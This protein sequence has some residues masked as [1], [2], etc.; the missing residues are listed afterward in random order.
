MNRSILFLDLA[1]TLG[2]AEGEPGERAVCGKHRLAPAGAKPGEILSGYM[3]FLVPRLQSFRP[4]RIV[5]ESPFINKM[6][7]NT[8]R[9]L[10]SLG[11]ITEMVGY[12]LGIVTLE[13]NLNTI[14]KATLGFVPRGEGVKESVMSHVRTLGYEPADDNAA[15]ALL[16]WLYACSVLDPKSAVATTPLFQSHD[17]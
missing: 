10:W 4:A 12:R 9:L 5:F 3:D 6:N 7:A 14:R 1:T 8:T 13:A 16:G 15:D 17:E 11:G 2:W